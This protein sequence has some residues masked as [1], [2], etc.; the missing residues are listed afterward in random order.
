[1]GKPV[2]TKHPKVFTEVRI[3]AMLFLMPAVI[4]F[5]LFVVYPI[6]QSARYSTY[7][8]NGLGPPTQFIGLD[9]YERLFADSLF[10]KALSNNLFVVVWSLITNIPLGVFLAILLTGRITGS[11]FFRTLYFSPMVLSGVIV[12]LL[13]QWIY[14]PSFGL[15]NSFLQSVGLEQLK[16]S[17]LGDGN[18]ALACVMV[19]ST[20]RD[21]GF[22]IV[23][24]IAAINDIP[25]EL[26]ASAKIDGTNNLQLHRYITLPL[27]NKTTI[28]TSVLVL[29]VL[30]NF[31]I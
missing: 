27:I 17:W 31:S 26:Y 4:I 8:W 28:V 15:A 18:I 6:I 9:N 20:W 5:G 16:S 29:S 7:S 1:M 22:F 23:I 11:T 12:G 10:W 13:W 25:E 21:L 24:F 30:Y 14:N 2:S 3:T 19:A